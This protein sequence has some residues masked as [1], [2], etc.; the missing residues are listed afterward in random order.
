MDGKRSQT[1]PFSGPKS[2]RS[3][4]RIERSA[5]AIHLSAGRGVLGSP[6]PLRTLIVST[7]ICWRSLRSEIPRPGRRDLKQASLPQGGTLGRTR[8]WRKMEASVSVAIATLRQGGSHEHRYC[9]GLGLGRFAAGQPG[10]EPWPRGD[11]PLYRVRHRRDRAR[12]P[13][14][15]GRGRGYGRRH[16]EPEPERGGRH[17]VLYAGGREPR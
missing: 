10:E 16:P 8:V 11:R 3:A 15:S 9:W 14:G 1:T 4:R 12:G 13:G 5:R 2:T 7:K 17:G 6:Y